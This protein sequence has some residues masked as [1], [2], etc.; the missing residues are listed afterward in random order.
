VILK[1][2]LDMEKHP[3]PEEFHEKNTAKGD[4]LSVSTI[5]RTLKVLVKTGLGKHC[6]IALWL[7]CCKKI[8]P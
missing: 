4:R 7:R 1:I 8:K 6:I 2:F 5:C 3:S